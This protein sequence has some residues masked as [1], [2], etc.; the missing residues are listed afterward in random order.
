MQKYE[1]CPWAKATALFVVHTFAARSTATTTT[2]AVN[3]ATFQARETRAVD[4]KAT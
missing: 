3:H 2:A 4:L 1:S